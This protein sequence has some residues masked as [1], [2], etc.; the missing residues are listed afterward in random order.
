MFGT[1]S[2]IRVAVSAVLIVMA[3]EAVLRRKVGVFLLGVG[4]LA[5]IAGIVF[6]LVT[7]LR[8]ATGVLL[9]LAALALLIANVRAYLGRR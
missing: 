4:V 1:I 6:L 2:S 7:D 5:S 3:V 9:L 8:T